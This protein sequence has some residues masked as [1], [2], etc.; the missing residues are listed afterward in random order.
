MAQVLAAAKHMA[1]VQGYWINTLNAPGYAG[2]VE[3]LVGA[4]FRYAEGDVSPEV[5]AAG[6]FGFCLQVS[7]KHDPQIVWHYD[8]AVG[9][10]QEGAA[11]DSCIEDVGGVVVAAAD[12]HASGATETTSGG[13]APS[14]FGTSGSASGSSSGSALDSGTQSGS[15]DFGSEQETPA[16]GDDGSGSGISADGSSSGN[17]GSN[18][19]GSDPADD[20]DD[21][22][23]NDDDEDDEDGQGGSG[24]GA[25]SEA[26]M[27]IEVGCYSVSVTSSKDISHVKV[28]FVDG[29]M[30]EIHLTGY[31]YSHTFDKAIDHATAKSGTTRVSDSPENCA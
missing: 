5:A 18:N 13:A 21:D 16:G 31:T 25:S 26:K 9:R 3:E 20:N 22:D 27:T 17:G 7:S 12:D 1:S 28:Y 2:T 15:D 24:D 30:R 6:R 29:T 4:G 14:E 8:S 19:S 10:P 11:D 23:G